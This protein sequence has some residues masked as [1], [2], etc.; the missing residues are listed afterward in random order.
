VALLRAAF[1]PKL[2]V[3]YAFGFVLGIASVKAGV[4]HGTLGIGVMLVM[5]AMA[6]LTTL[7][8]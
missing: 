2:L 6:L 7:S 4:V 1:R 3:T 8:D 5:G